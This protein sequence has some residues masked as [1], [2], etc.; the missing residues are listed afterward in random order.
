MPRT[1]TDEEYNFL[2]GRRQIA[3][4]IE[5][6]YHDP[7]LSKDAKALIKRKYPNLQI[8][9]HDLEEKFEKRLEEERQ[10]REAAE[11]ERRNQQE[12]E[13]FNSVR[14]K[15]QDAYGFTDQAMDELE[16]LMVEKNVGDYEVA[17]TYMAS[18][19]PKPSDATA[20]DDGLWNHSKAPGFVEI[21]KDPEGWG[22]GEILKALHKDQERERNQRF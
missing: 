9:E 12:Q 10:A 21:A 13:R 11:A 4:F 15:T 16:K 14:K 7:A 22:R 20:F 19:Q 3:D 5:P 6:I 2:Q 1:I 17:A 8:P 18:K